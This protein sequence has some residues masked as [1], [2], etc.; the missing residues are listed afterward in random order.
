MW[1]Y[2]R[3]ARTPAVKASSTRNSGVGLLALV[4]AQSSMSCGTRDVPPQALPA[5]SVLAVDE[6]GLTAEE[7]DAAADIWAQLDPAASATHLRQLALTN[8]LFPLCGGRLAAPEARLAARQVIDAAHAALLAGQV[9]R[10]IEI[11]EVEGTWQALTPI[12]WRWALEAQPGQVSPVLEQ[13]GTWAFA[14]LHS[15][16]PAVSARDVRM[17]LT[18]YHRAWLDPTR[19]LTTIDERLSRATLRSADAAWLDLVP[20]VWQKKLNVP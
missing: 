4:L 9:P 16:T 1:L 8:T 15:V 5:G 12:V 18:V 6:V 7:I 17:K 10:D 14:R 20:L 3:R 2:R 13:P 19:G 11:N